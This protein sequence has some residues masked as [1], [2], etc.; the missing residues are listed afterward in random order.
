MN[1]SEYLKIIAYKLSGECFVFGDG[2]VFKI[3]DVDT[4]F[5]LDTGVL[6]FWKH[7]KEIM[8]NIAPFFAYKE[9]LPVK[10]TAFDGSKYGIQDVYGKV[11]DSES[12][13]IQLA[14]KKVN[15]QGYALQNLHYLPDTK[16]TFS[17][18]LGGYPKTEEEL[19]KDWEFRQ[20]VDLKY[21]EKPV[22]DILP[23]ISKPT[24][25]HLTKLKIATILITLANKIEQKLKTN[26]AN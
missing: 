25:R 21:S 14:Y 8:I 9:F 24:I 13:E 18:S 2:E 3:S 7:E 23:Y 10:V 22:F 6:P 15:K 4:C 20:G 5:V 26:A 12:L 1:L 19:N 17:A 16:K 11:I